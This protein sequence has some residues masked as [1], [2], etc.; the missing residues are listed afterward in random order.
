MEPRLTVFPPL[1]PPEASDSSRVERNGFVD[2]LRGLS[3]LMVMCLHLGLP[4]WLTRRLPTWTSRVVEDAYYFVVVFFAVSGFLIASTSIRRF[5]ALETIDIGEFIVLR[6]ARILPFLFVVLALLVSLGTLHA[7]GFDFAPGVS[8]LSAAYAALSFQFNYWFL[9]HM[10]AETQ[11]WAALWSLSIEEIFYGVFPMLCVL[12]RSRKAIVFWLLFAIPLALH[13]RVSDS[14]G[15]Y[16]ATGCVDALAVGILVALLGQRPGPVR[17]GFLAAVLAY[18]GMAAGLALILL[19]SQHAHPTKSLGAGPLLCSLGTGLY[20]FASTRVPAASSLFARTRPWARA[21]TIPLI[22]PAL[23]GRASYEAYLLHLPIKLFVLNYVYQ[24]F[25][26]VVLMGI[27]GIVSYGLNATFTE[28]VSRM[29]RG[30][31]SAKAE[32]R[33]VTVASLR[34]AALPAMLAAAL[35]LVPL[36]VVKAAPP[37]ASSVRS[38][39][40]TIYGDDLPANP[41]PLI[42]Y[43]ASKDAEFLSVKKSADGSVVWQFDHWGL[44]SV[45]KTLTPSFKDGRCVVVLNCA[46][47]SVSVDGKEVLTGADMKGFA[48]HGQVFLGL[49]KVGGGTMGAAYSGRIRDTVIE[50]DTGRKWKERSWRSGI[51]RQGED[52]R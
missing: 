52:A 18:L 48:S 13:V 8:P 10:T 27:I 17:G 14:S 36:L 6:A 12:L 39:S 37:E 3:I 26:P 20:L 19:V 49:N 16:L 41:E 33:R 35:L 43:G 45:T 42:V 40:L 22:W 29:I 38:V 15:L 44:P 47:P 24:T 7:K 34:C 25:D 4:P 30:R 28:P 46:S 1:M 23:L 32:P 51:L 31:L 50:L 2:W 11:P 9:A 21:L 5:R